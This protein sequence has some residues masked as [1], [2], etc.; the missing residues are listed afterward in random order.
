MLEDKQQWGDSVGCVSL[1]GF[2]LSAI[3]FTVGH[4][5]QVVELVLVLGMTLFPVFMYYFSSNPG[6]QKK[7]HTPCSER[8]T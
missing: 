2:G 7:T 5:D 8:M 4:R 3:R 6:R 1:Q